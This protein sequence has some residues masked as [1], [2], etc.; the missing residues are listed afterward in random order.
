MIQN[1]GV[2]GTRS[3]GQTVRVNLNDYLGNGYVG[4]DHNGASTSYTLEYA[5]SDF[6]LSQFALAV[7]DKVANQTYLAHALNWGTLFNSQTGYITPRNSDGTF[8]SID[9]SSQTGFT[10][11]SQAQYTW[12]VPFDQR[13]LFDAMGGNSAVV[14][15]LDTFFTR[16]NDLPDSIYAFMGNEPCEET[17]WTYDFAGAPW[18]TQSVVRR[19]QTQLFT[20]LPNG[21]P[22]NDD[23]GS[24]SSWYVF[25]ALGLYPDIPGVGGFVVG[26]PLFQS[27]VMN[28]SG[29]QK[30]QILAPKA[31]D[32]NPFVQSMQINGVDNTHLW[33]PVD[34][35]LNN[36]ATTLTFDLGNSPNLDWGSSPDD[37]PPSWD[38][39]IVPDAPANLS[40]TAGNAQ[41]TL[42]WSAAAT[43][44]SYNIYR[45]T[46]PGEEDGT[47]IAT[48]VRY[49]A[50]LDSG[51][52]NGK[53]YYYFVTA[54]NSSGESS[55]S[56]EVFATPQTSP[57]TSFHI[58]FSDNLR[59]V[60][61]GYVNDNGLAFGDR[62]SSGFWFGWNQDNAE[63]CRDRDD[64]RSPDERYDS[65]CH[66][67]KPGNPDAFWQIAVPNG[68]YTVHLVAGDPMDV[69]DA[70][71]A[72]N[73]QGI[74]AVSGT[75]TPA[76]KFFEGTLSVIVQNGLITVSNAAG[77]ANNKIAFI[78]ITPME[79]NRAVP[80]LGNGG[81][82]KQQS[83]GFRNNAEGLRPPGESL[84]WS[85]LFIGN[86]LDGRKKTD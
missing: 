48:G 63:N 70:V 55:P 4:Q 29:G 69:F 33:L 64:P 75:P 26:S 61:V 73:V 77:S 82:E 10:E 14:T 81:A 51:L 30:V 41:V 46:A 50:Y 84:Q 53:T 35:L 19:I 34:L 45:G 23:A 13:G 60:F 18:K 24:L 52:V 7:G 67:Q 27:I 79:G 42:S 8:L 21:I 17:P 9:P 65:F 76:N 54:V 74:L 49:P 36:P 12:M 83:R 80:G 1:A 15:R 39:S 37:A 86:E 68:T 47:P 3:D 66:M 40:A 28:L 5:S 31:A 57:G 2:I 56:E 85:Y 32:A 22:G 62:G 11:G 6:A 72:I 44:T 78:D 38:Q 25:S 20:T 43:A 16:L 59:E 58:N 71:Y